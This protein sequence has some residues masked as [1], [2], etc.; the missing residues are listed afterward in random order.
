MILLYFLIVIVILYYWIIFKIEPI[1]AFLSYS[2]SKLATASVSIW[3]K[4]VVSAF[5]SNILLFLSKFK[6]NFLECYKTDDGKEGIWFLIILFLF[7]IPVF[8]LCN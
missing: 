4:A 5:K 7:V 6:G 8:I 2:K 3:V 1:K